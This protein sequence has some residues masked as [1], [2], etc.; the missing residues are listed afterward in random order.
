MGGLFLWWILGPTGDHLTR[1]YEAED[2]RDPE[3]AGVQGYL[4]YTTELAGPRISYITGPV[5]YG[6]PLNTLALMRL[7]GCTRTRLAFFVASSS[8]PS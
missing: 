8:V 4:G 3:E 1:D 7:A 6:T 5:N 2:D